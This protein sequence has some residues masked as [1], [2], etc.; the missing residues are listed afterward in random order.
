VLSDDR[1]VA[2]L[3]AS[4]AEVTTAH[5]AEVSKRVP[6]AELIVQLDEPALAVQEGGWPPG[7]RRAGSAGG[8]ARSTP[9]FR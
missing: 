8:K 9:W 3:T 7:S 1:T 5:V 4:L 6:G 2:D